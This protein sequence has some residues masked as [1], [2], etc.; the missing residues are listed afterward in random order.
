MSINIR[1]IKI[2]IDTNIPG[3]KPFPL[4]KSVLYNP[5]LKNTKNFEEYP[6]FTMD[7][8][9]P[10]SYLN[11]LSYEKRLEFFFNKPIMEKLLRTMNKEL[12]KRK[13]EEDMNDAI[14]VKT[15]EQQAQEYESNTESNRRLADIKTL[16]EMIKTVNNNIET[17]KTKNDSVKLQEQQNAYANFINKKEMNKN[18]NQTVTIKKDGIF[19]KNNN[20]VSPL[21]INDIP[22]TTI[23]GYITEKKKEFKENTKE[24]TELLEDMKTNKTI[25]K[26]FEENPN[27]KDKRVKRVQEI[28]ESAKEYLNKIQQIFTLY[29]IEYDDLNTK[30]E[31][32]KKDIAKMTIS[33]SKDAKEKLI[34]LN[35]EAVNKFNRFATEVYDKN[36]EDFIQNQTSIIADYESTIDEEKKKL[37]K[38]IQDKN[39]KLDNV[40]KIK[41]QELEKK[42]E[43]FQTQIK[44]KTSNTPELI[45]TQKNAQEIALNE[46]QLQK[47][48][49]SNS[50][51]NITIL[52]RILFPTKYPFVNNYFSSF[53]SVI[54][55]N[56]ETN[57][58]MNSVIPMFLKKKLI[59]GLTEYSYIKLDGKTYTV[60]QVI[61]LNDIYNH[62]E[63]R[64]LVDQFQAVTKWKTIQ[65]T[66]LGVEINTKANKFRT[67]YGKNGPYYFQDSDID[68]IKKQFDETK[69]STTSSSGP[70]TTR[71]MDKNIAYKNTLNELVKTIGEF[72]DIL[73]MQESNEALF[74]TAKNL[75]A[76][77]KEVKTYGTSYFKEMD[78]HSKI[79]NNM[80]KDLND[81]KVDQFIM[82]NY[83]GRPGVNLDYKRE[84]DPQ[85]KNILTSKYKQYTE[86]AEKIQQ[87]RAPTRESFNPLLQQTINEFLDN[88]EPYKGVFN[89]MLNPRYIRMN[90]LEKLNIDEDDKKNYVNRMKTSVSVLPSSEP[91]YEIYIRLNVIGG[92]LNDSNKSLVDCLYQGDSLGGK[93]EYLMN[94]TLYNQWDVDSANIYFDITQGHAKQEI[95]KAEKEKA[96]KEKAETVE[97]AK[98]AVESVKKG[99]NITRKIKEH[100][101][102]TR[103]RYF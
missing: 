14:Q 23:A 81:I 54:L 70:Y 31:K 38:D 99:G 47:K 97:K 28:K 33:T 85:Y 11:T 51:E 25:E 88:T 43:E 57:F 93:L 18:K 41:L 74:D 4:T 30:I 7:V 46:A 83:I 89:F 34:K 64:K 19:I 96:E 73:R 56:P 90:P 22:I 26:I 103:K 61:W 78:K 20:S 39:A 69:M 98:A 68:Y 50:E 60:I 8:K 1:A 91:T 36:T 62:V 49:L 12:F 52:L 29:D 48:Q 59:D 21:I 44:D 37:D 77:Y 24:I 27:D 82:D 9:F 2:M 66:K 75:I 87:F 102:K 35:K 3:K 32:N 5:V 84:E 71:T 80:T 6:Y 65:N 17:E 55:R 15:R 67:T 100:F 95:E 86:F 53:N 79:V 13:P 101:I 94:E 58:S 40:L 16:R 42:I 63:Y 72:N 45:A 92:E 76:L 10:E